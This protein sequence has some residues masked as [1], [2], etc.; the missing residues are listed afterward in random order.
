VQRGLIDIAR[1][2]AKA[3]EIC[4]LLCA[5][6]FADTRDALIGFYGNDVETLIEV[7]WRVWILI[8]ADARDLHT[9]WRS[10]RRGTRLRHN[11]GAATTY[12]SQKRTALHR[13]SFRLNTC[14]SAPTGYARGRKRI[15]QEAGKV[16]LCREN[17]KHAALFVTNLD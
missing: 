3:I 8:K 5:G 12:G 7:R 4:P 10:Q 15:N 16:F 9:D 1:R 2:A 13:P 6:A 17:Y 11:G 14:R